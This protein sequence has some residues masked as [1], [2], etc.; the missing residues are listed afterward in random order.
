MLTK[1][2]TSIQLNE[3]D[4]IKS[5]NETTKLVREINDRLDVVGS[6]NLFE[7]V[8]DPTSFSNTVENIFYLSFLV[9]DGRVS[10]EDSDGEPI[11]SKSWKAAEVI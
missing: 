8:I 5:E 2:A 6:I 7:F 9:R 11:L 4:I 10:I 1:A 3:E